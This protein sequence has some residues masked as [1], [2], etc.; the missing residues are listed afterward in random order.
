MEP[1]VLE[2]YN[3]TSG[4]AKGCGFELAWEAK[5]IH[6]QEIG[7]GLKAAFA[8]H[9]SR[10]SLVISYTAKTDVQLYND[11]GNQLATV[12][13]SGRVSALLHLTS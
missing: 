7:K 1:A 5:S 6:N 8:P 10:K 4:S 2:K 12:N 3:F 9:T 11:T 13:S